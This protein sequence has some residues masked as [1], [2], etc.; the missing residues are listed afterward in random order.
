MSFF[1]CPI[2]TAFFTSFLVLSVPILFILS[3][4]VSSPSFLRYS[5]LSFLSFFTLSCFSLLTLLL[6]SSNIL[7]PHSFLPYFL[8]LSSGLILPSLFLSSFILVFHVSFLPSS[9]NPITFTYF[10]LLLFIRSCF[11]NYSIPVYSRSVAFFRR[12]AL[13]LSICMSKYLYKYLPFCLS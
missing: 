7:S 8:F 11:L 13:P 9:F 10:N 12:I 2:F 3:F 6:S 4:P 5:L 1:I